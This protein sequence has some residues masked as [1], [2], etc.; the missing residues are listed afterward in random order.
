MIVKLTSQHIPDIAKAQVLAWQKA[1]QG[2]LSAATLND[3]KI[4]DFEA[5]WRQIILQTQR[6]NY[7]WLTADQQAVGFVSFGPPKDPKET[8]PYEIYGIYVHPDFWHQ[9]IG[10]ELMKAAV[11]DLRTKDAKEAIMLWVMSQNE[12]SRRF[13]DRFGFTWDGATRTSKR[14]EDDFE[15][16]RY[17]YKP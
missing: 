9:K 17:V 3:L 5:N 1:F 2:I 16:V 13:Y 12:G 11:D 6:T 15:E 7:I 14:L 10:Y 8:L 4:A